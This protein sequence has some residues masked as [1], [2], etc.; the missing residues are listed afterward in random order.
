MITNHLDIQQLHTPGQHG[1][2]TDQVSPDLKG[3]LHFLRGRALNATAEYSAEAEEVLGRA[4]RFN[5]PSAWNELGE[6]QYKKGDLTGALTCFEKALRLAQD[7]VYYRNMSMLMRSLPWKTSN[8]RE[9]NIE[10]K[11]AILNKI[12]WVSQFGNGGQ[13]LL[14]TELSIIVAITA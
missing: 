1:F 2:G 7:K 3:E 8:E 6:C 9:E 5:L 11:L 4:T 12:L 13:G 14:I 10:K